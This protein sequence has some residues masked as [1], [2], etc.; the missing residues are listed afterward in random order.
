[1]DQNQKVDTRLILILLLFSSPHRA[2]RLGFPLQREGKCFSCFGCNTD[3]PCWSLLEKHLPAARRSW[4]AQELGVTVKWQPDTVVSSKCFLFSTKPDNFR[5]VTHL[6]ACIFPAGNSFILN[7]IVTH[8]YFEI[9]GIN[10]KLQGFNYWRRLLIVECK[11]GNSF[12]SCQA[13]AF[14]A[15]VIV[16]GGLHQQLCR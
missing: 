11:Q 16:W 1:M 2:F 8:P 4:T 13:A 15:T 12:H 3:N 10:Y 9:T 7:E 14:S 5:A 6:F